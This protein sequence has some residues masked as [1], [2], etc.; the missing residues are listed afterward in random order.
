MLRSNLKPTFVS[1]SKRK[2][3]TKENATNPA[4]IEN[5]PGILSVEAKRMGNNCTGKNAASQ[6]A[7]EVNDTARPK[8]N[9]KVKKINQYYY[10]IIIVL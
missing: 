3:N 10:I 6:S 9:S 1:G 2:V 5:V 8:Q 4:M 7:P